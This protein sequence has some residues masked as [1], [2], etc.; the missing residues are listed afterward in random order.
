MPPPV[1]SNVTNV[2]NQDYSLASD[3]SLNILTTSLILSCCKN[4]RLTADDKILE[5]VLKLLFTKFEKTL[6]KRSGKS[7][8]FLFTAL[9]NVLLLMQEFVSSRTSDCNSNSEHLQDVFHDILYCEVPDLEKEVKEVNSNNTEMIE[10]L[11]IFYKKLMT[12]ISFD[13]WIES[14]DMNCDI[15]LQNDAG[16]EYWPVADSAAPSN[17]QM[18]IAHH[19]A[20]CCQAFEVNLIF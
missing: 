10:N 19:Q 20:L 14:S 18:L 9:L 4:P 13:D 11:L 3:T 17:M 16:V 2:I 7:K 12:E 15:V 5:S 8:E 6:D 1:L